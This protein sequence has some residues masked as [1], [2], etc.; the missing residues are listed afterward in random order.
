MRTTNLTPEEQKEKRR[1]YEIEY[2]NKNAEKKK[3]LNKLYYEATKK[4]RKKEYDENKEQ[5]IKQNKKYREENKVK[6]KEQRKI[7]RKEN[8]EQLNE[9]F[10]EK[11]KNDPLFKLSCNL[12]SN[13]STSI[14]RLNKNK[15]SKTELILG[16]SFAEFKT[17]LENQFESWMTWDNYGLYNSTPNYGWDI[18]HIIAQSN[19][20]TY[21]EL[22]KLN[23]YTNLKPLCSYI[24]RDVKKNN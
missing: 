2:R 1:L 3:E 18:D 11:R 4:K 9:Y 21:D 17:Y 24:N 8:K 15:Q 12:R 22:I 10:K 14:K 5:I 7:Y 19:A 23:H 16:C 6:I 13:I 20:L